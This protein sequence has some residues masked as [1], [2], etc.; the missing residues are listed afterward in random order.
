MPNF[1]GIRQN[2]CLLE[3]TGRKVQLSPSLSSTAFCSSLTHLWKDGLAISLVHYTDCSGMLYSQLGSEPCCATLP[4]RE[5]HRPCPEKI[6][7][8]LQNNLKSLQVLSRCK[9][10]DSREKKKYVQESFHYEF[11]C[12]C[13]LVWSSFEVLVISFLPLL[14]LIET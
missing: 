1:W 2:D 3:L 7:E 14:Q 5:R 8:K 13:L 6:Q 11:Q 4:T 12:K 10:P 9:W